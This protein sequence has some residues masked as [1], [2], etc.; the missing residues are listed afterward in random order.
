M[1]IRHLLLVLSLGASL[2]GALNLSDLV[3]DT[4]TT[5]TPE[6]TETVTGTPLP[7]CLAS[8]FYSVDMKRCW[9]IETPTPELD[10]TEPTA[11][12]DPN[13]YDNDYHD[14]GIC[15]EY[16]DGGTRIIY[17]PCD[18]VPESSPSP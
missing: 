4:D 13:P 14:A 16:V 9:P 15:F 3:D 5:A 7:E 2:A 11:T 8:E 18:V 1:S 12:D 17:Y 6:I 10:A